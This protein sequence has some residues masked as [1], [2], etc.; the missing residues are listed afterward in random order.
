MESPTLGCIALA[1]AGFSQS[2]SLVPM[3][4][5]LLRSAG[6]RFRGRI[7]GV[8]QL[9]IYGSPL[10]LLAAGALIERIGFAWTASFY[11]LVGTGL[12]GIITLYWRAAL[13]PVDAPANAR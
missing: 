1:L 11:C 6:E 4:V 3:S 13:W 8:R 5:L 7:M 9:A 10:G 12:I 2:L